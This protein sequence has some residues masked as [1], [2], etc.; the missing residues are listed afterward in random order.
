MAACPPPPTRA[1]TLQLAMAATIVSEGGQ[2]PSREELQAKMA[3]A[4]KVRGSCG[5]VEGP[6]LQ[7]AGGCKGGGHRL[8]RQMPGRIGIRT[9]RPT[10]TVYSI[11]RY[12]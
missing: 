11:L 10:V 2:Q 3:A 6:G 1:G 4:Q 12:L 8:L 9:C 5:W 7:G